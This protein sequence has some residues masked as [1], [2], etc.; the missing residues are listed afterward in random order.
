MIESDFKSDLSPVQYKKIR[1][2]VSQFVE[3]WGNVEFIK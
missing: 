2:I 3:K 1:D